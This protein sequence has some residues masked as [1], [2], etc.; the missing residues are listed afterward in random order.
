MDKDKEE[1]EMITKN[2]TQTAI[3]T[4]AAV[5]SL[6]KKGMKKYRKMLDKLAKN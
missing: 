6:A 2:E 3:T 4:D 1:K 5:K